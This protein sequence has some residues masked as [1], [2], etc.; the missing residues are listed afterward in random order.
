MTGTLSLSTAFLRAVR[1]L[2]EPL[3]GFE[4]EETNTR[5]WESGHFA[6]ARH[7]FIFRFIG[8]HA[9]RAANALVR[10]IASEDLDVEGQLVADITLCSEERTR[11]PVCVLMK[12]E[13][14]T[15]CC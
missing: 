2:L 10:R 15:V 4:L 1:L 3:G 8:D 12:I 13:A 14:L 7:Q 6:G 5:R 9:E 11:S